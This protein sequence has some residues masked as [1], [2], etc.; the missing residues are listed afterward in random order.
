MFQFKPLIRNHTEKELFDNIKNVWLILGR[1]PRYRD[2]KK[3]LSIV[4]AST[5]V[6]RFGTFNNALSSF[7]KSLSLTDDERIPI[8]ESITVARHVT[9]R[10]PSNRLKVLVLM[11]DGNKCRLCGEILIGDEIRFDHITPWSK[12]GETTLENL[13]VLCEEHNTAKGNAV[14]LSSLSETETVK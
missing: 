10:H 11:R 1:Q 5:Y 8:E 2:F 13:Q 7:I 14:L 12:G 9:Q 4:S 6:E 3:P